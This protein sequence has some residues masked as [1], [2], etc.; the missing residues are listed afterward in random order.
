MPSIR[1]ADYSLPRVR[2]PMSLASRL[3]LAYAAATCLLLLVAAG[4]MYYQLV[5][6]LMKENIYYLSD[7]VRE[8]HQNLTDPLVN[9]LSIRSYVEANS[10]GDQDAFKVYTRV[11]K[12]G[13][14]TIAESHG[15]ADFLPVTQF[16]PVPTD[17]V[18]Q[19]DWKTI[20]SL[21]GRRFL[22]SSVSAGNRNAR[23]V[24]QFALDLV[25]EDKLLAG[26]RDRIRNILVP[27][28]LAAIFVSYVLARGG[29][30]PLRKV[31]TAVRRVQTTTL[32]ERVDPS[33]FPGELSRLASSFND[34]LS[35]I[36]DAFAR[37]SRFSADIAHEL[38][39]P[40]GC[41]RGELE[42]ALGKAR[43]PQ[44]YREVMESCLEECVRLGQLIDRL[45]FL[46]RAERQEAMLKLETIDL[47]GE[48]EKVRDFYEAGAAEKGVALNIA[49][50]PGLQVKLDKTLLQSALGNLIQNAIA[51]TP[52]GGSVTL[53]GARANG[54]MKLEVAD[55]GRGISPDH[56]PFVL[57]RFYR[58]DEARGR[59]GGNLGLGL[60]IV[61]SIAILHGGEVKVDSKLGEGT[62]VTILI[63]SI[64]IKSN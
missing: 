10:P 51:H 3:T 14:E 22:I 1:Q 39:T 38:R 56:L 6:S 9:D 5:A 60:A 18:S 34:M 37:L 57:D 15:M 43:S 26:Y 29:L 40:L 45:L 7:E 52:R 17:G 23:Y 42:V 25:L 36:E 62:R 46:A 64:E 41:L 16:A 19:S 63:P 49:F 50:E 55:T 61:K 8:A 2:R 27:S 58:A 33:G 48:M 4:L 53:S 24:V 59:Q 28:L 13:G 31:V 30:R 35:R 32:D 44:E 54:H 20:Q 21:D 12:A 47:G 11:L